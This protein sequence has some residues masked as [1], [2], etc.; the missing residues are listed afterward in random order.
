MRFTAFDMSGASR[1]RSLWATYYADAHAL[2]FVLDSADRLRGRG[3]EP[4]ARER[5]A[6]VQ[7]H[8]ERRR[9]LERQDEAQAVLGVVLVLQ[10]QGLAQEAAVAAA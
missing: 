4:G 2:L 8:Q 6:A 5:D 9:R 1:Y 7:R 10:G 3:R